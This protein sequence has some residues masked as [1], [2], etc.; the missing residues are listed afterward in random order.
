MGND[1]DRHIQVSHFCILFIN[2]EIGSRMLNHNIASYALQL[3]IGPVKPD[4]GPADTTTCSAVYV[5]CTYTGWGWSHMTT[6][7]PAR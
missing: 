6:L 7:L 4:P 1:I 2:S 5:Y 3:C